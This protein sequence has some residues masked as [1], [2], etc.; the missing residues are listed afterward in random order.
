MSD[1]KIN[2]ADAGQIGRQVAG[3]TDQGIKFIP[4]GLGF[5][6]EDIRR[7]FPEA[8]LVRDA[9]A[10]PSAFSRALVASIQEASVQ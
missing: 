10:L 5:E 7:V 9:A 8:E 2:R 4:F 6:G 3:I 1:G